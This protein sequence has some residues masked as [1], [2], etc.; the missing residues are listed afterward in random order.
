MDD[1]IF[2][3]PALKQKQQLEEIKKCNE[4]SAKFGVTLSDSEVIGL[5]ENRKESLKSMGRVEL[6]NGI[7]PKLIFEFCDSPFIYQDIYADTLQALQ[8]IFYYFK[9][10]SLDEIS[11]DELIHIM[12]EYFDQECQ[13]S[14]E[15]LQETTLEDICRNV[16]YGYGTIRSYD[17]ED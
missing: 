4:Y 13:G 9:N 15:Y 2:N 1:E 6:G 7:L 10:E 14:I 11:D 5:N 8:E 3:L 17:E 16:R 12:R